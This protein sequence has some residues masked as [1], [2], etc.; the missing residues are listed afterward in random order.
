VE[1][2]KLNPEVNHD[3]GGHVAPDLQLREKVL[4]RKMRGEVPKLQKSQ[5]PEVNHDR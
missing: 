3:S 1:R 4:W 2:L 5:S